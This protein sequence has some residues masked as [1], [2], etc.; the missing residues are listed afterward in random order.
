MGNTT[1]KIRGNADEKES[2]LTIGQLFKTQRLQQKKSL[3]D[4]ADSLKIRKVFLQAIEDEQFDQLPGG[5]YTVGF[6]RSYAQYLGLDPETIIEQL[7]DE[8]FFLPV[9]L[10][11]IGDEQHFPPNRFVSSGMILAGLFLLILG[12]I[13]AYIF[14]GNQEEV[15]VHINWAASSIE[16]ADTKIE[17]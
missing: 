11:M 8:S 6:I 15:P 12:A 5:V 17:L 3:E 1:V 9:Q 16:E 7:K 10:T 4:V 13:A 2:P 14:L